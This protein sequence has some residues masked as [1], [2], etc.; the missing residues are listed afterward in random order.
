MKQAIVTPILK[1][2]NSDW[3]DLQNYRPV[4][5]IGFV[6]KV[7]EKA[8]MTQVDEYMQINDLD[9]VNQS[10]YKIKHSTETALLKVTNDIAFALAENKAAFLIM[11]DLSAAFDT[12][13]HDILLHRL[14]HDFGIKGTALQWFRSYMSGRTFKVSVGGTFSHHFDLKYGVPQG[15]IIGPRIF[16][17]YSQ[18]VASII[19]R[20]GL[21]FHC[22]SDD[23][24]I[25]AI[26]DPNVPGDAACAIF[27][28]L[29]CVEELR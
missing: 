5:N 19:R 24:Q 9:E 23:V 12:I 25:Y 2:T 11:L 4:S 27:K 14:E 17:M 22:Y 3:N 20:H 8:A 1:K 29:K 7:I 21:Y 13:D 16:T 6:S 15:S 10:A 18:N 26:F 28:L